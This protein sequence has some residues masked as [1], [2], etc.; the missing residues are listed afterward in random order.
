MLTKIDLPISEKLA[1]ILLY[2]PLYEFI[3]TKL[4]WNVLA[5]VWM[6]SDAHILYIIE[7]RVR[8]YNCYSKTTIETTKSINIPEI[9]SLCSSEDQQDDKDLETNDLVIYRQIDTF[10]QNDRTI[11]KGIRCFVNK[12]LRLPCKINANQQHILYGIGG[13]FYLYFLLNSGY[14]N[15][16]H[17]FSNNSNIIDIAKKNLN[18]YVKMK[19]K[20]CLVNYDKFQMQNQGVSSIIINLSSLPIN[21]FKQLVLNTF[22]SIVIITCNQEVFNKR[23]NILE[24]KYRLLDFRHIQSKISRTIVSIYVY[25]LP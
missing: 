1:D 9:I 14:F 7:G 3:S 11:T 4:G 24:T 17:G 22:K 23:R 13:E 21:V 18:N 16:F 10:Q 6:A 15:R 2:P 8:V 12:N 5:K 19:Y 25:F 20:L